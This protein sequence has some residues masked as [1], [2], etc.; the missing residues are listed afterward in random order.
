[1]KRQSLRGCSP[2]KRFM[3]PVT[4][5]IVG[6]AATFISSCA[7]DAVDVP[8]D[9]IPA[10]LPSTGYGWLPFATC[11]FP[12]FAASWRCPIRFAS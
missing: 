2:M 10:P 7:R 11:R 5:L 3:A 8:P 6:M 12:V 4:W 9:P 1:M